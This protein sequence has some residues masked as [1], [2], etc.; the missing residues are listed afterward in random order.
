M[1]RNAQG[2]YHACN[3]EH[4]VQQAP[5]VELHLVL[6]QGQIVQNL[7]QDLHGTGTKKAE[8]SWGELVGSQR[9][10]RGTGLLTSRSSMRAALAV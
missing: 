3:V 2:T 8:E 10:L 5:V 4:R 6:A 9:V 1:Q 7:H